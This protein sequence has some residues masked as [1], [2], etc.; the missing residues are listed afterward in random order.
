MVRQAAGSDKAKDLIAQGSSI[1]AYTHLNDQVIHRKWEQIRSNETM[2][3]Y[4]LGVTQEFI[5]RMGGMKGAPLSSL[6]EAFSDSLIYTLHEKS[7]MD[8]TIRERAIPEKQADGFADIMRR[9]IWFIVLI[10]SGWVDLHK[11]QVLSSAYQRG[12]VGM[13]TPSARS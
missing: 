7:Y 4:L 10:L 11:F 13:P 9:N 12:S 2:L 8:E 5:F 3:D 6:I 1:A